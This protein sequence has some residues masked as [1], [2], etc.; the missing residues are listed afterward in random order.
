[1]PL[2]TVASL[3]ENITNIAQSTL[4]SSNETGIDEILTKEPSK[5]KSILRAN[6]I[7]DKVIFLL[8]I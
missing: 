2:K 5:P 8:N 1:M 7:E 6:Q 4:N 3:V